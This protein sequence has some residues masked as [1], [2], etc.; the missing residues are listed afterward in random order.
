MDEIVLSLIIATVKAF[1]AEVAKALA[2]RF[3]SRK[4]EGTAPTA[5]EDTEKVNTKEGQK[6]AVRARKLAAFLI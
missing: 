4:K 5:N 6:K 2:K 3:V 1:F